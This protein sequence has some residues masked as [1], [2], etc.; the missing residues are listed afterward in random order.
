MIDIDNKLNGDIIPQ[1]KEKI[2]QIEGIVT[3]R[4]I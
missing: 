4:I 2:E 1:L 3:A